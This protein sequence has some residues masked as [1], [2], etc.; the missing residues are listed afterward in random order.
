VEDRL[1][2]HARLGLAMSDFVAF[3]VFLSACWLVL[4]TSAAGAQAPSAIVEEVQGKTAGV[5]I[6]DYLVPGKVLQLAPNDQIVLGYLKSCWRESIVAGTVTVGA[7]QSEVKGG[8][9]ERTKVPC[10]PSHIA[11]TAEQA[12]KSGAMAFRKGPQKG[13]PEPELTLYGLSPVIETKTAGRLLI[14]RLDKKGEQLE[15]EI[16]GPQLLR[17][18]FFDLAKADR[19]LEAGGLYRATLGTRQLV[20]KM[21][22]LAKP[23]TGPLIGRLL[24]FTPAT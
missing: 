12:K 9:V 19:S 7:E 22:S 13:N 15:L 11:L 17:G 3:R 4:A 2:L 8:K 21:D 1:L 24:R 20:F 18:Q 14:E 23:G 10:D 16:K 6:M 5:E